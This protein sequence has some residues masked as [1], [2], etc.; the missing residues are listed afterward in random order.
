MD[1]IPKDTY[2]PKGQ[3]YVNKKKSR[4]ETAKR[5]S[6]K[7][8]D[9]GV[10]I[11]ANTDA[12]NIGTFPG[13]SIYREFELLKEAGL[14]PGNILT[15]VTINAAKL[16]R[17]EKY[18]GS[19]S[20]KKLA[21]LVILNSDPRIDIMNTTDISLVIKDGNIFRPDEI[22]VKTPEQLI[23][24]EVNAYNAGDIDNFME[25]F[26]PEI[27]VFNYP[28]EL[29]FENKADKREAYKKLFEN[30]PN[31][32]AEIVERMTIGNFVIDKEKI[33]GRGDAPTKYVIA[34]Y[35]IKDELIYRVY[36]MRDN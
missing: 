19:V 13:P 22:L 33:T 34:M 12:G 1:I 2:K 11:A 17:S 31:N 30:Y 24:Q 5:N 20:E 18:L 9:S 21:D 14:S 4:I 27:K 29:R 3:D 25:T 23:Q 10:L 15:S 16:M 28:D 26:H 36:F 35:E 8:Y 6:K 7:L 32:H